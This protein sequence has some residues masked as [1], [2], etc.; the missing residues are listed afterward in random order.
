MQTLEGMSVLL[1]ALPLANIAHDCPEAGEPG[2]LVVKEAGF[3]VDTGA[4]KFMGIKCHCSGLAPQ[5]TMTVA[6]IRA[7]IIHGG[8]EV[9][10]GKPL[11]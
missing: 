11:A 8:A 9:V 3:G 5:Y 2:E 10:A 6:T 4:E 1:H 7:L